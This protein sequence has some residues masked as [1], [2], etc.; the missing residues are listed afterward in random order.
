MMYTLPIVYH[1]I[2]RNGLLH[3]IT[4]CNIQYGCHIEVAAR[5]AKEQNQN[6][7]NTAAKKGTTGTAK[8]GGISSETCLPAPLQPASKP[9]PQI[10]PPSD[11]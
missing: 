6:Y 7:I 5:S 11:F 2:M 3:I 4:V 10:P 9:T 1:I 8:V